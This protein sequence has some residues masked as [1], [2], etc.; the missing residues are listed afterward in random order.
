VICHIKGIQGWTIIAHG[1]I[2]M[3]TTSPKKLN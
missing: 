1:I 3:S 2:S